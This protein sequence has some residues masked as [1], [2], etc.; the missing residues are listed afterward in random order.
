MRLR[1]GWGSGVIARLAVDL[2]AEFP[3]MTGLS[4]SNLH[5]MR[6]LAAAWPERSAIV[7]QPVG[8]LPWGHITVLL[9]RFEQQPARDWYAAE[10]VAHGWSRNVLL[11]QIKNRTL[12]RSGAA[13][14]NFE[15]KLPHPDSE[16][17]QQIA[18]DPYVFDFLGLGEEVAERQLER[19]LTDRMEE[20]LRE[21]GQGFA[22]VGRQVHFDVGG[23]DF[24]ICGSRNDH[25]V[26]YS[27]GRSDSPMAVAT[28][29]YESLPPAEQAALPDADVL[30]WAL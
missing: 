30:V 23:D 19:A 4:R 14:S 10:A 27:L 13:P 25:T 18:K 6:G 21:L 17:A 16:L 12:E 2:R 29:A 1:D 7:Q 24:L 26:R 8:Q 22:F 5:Y 15:A 9:D 11:N 28:Y 3:Q 20:T